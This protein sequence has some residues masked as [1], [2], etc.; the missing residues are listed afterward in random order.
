MSIELWIIGFFVLTTIYLWLETIGLK[1][2]LR[3][4]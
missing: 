1:Q 3:E 4:R 2:K